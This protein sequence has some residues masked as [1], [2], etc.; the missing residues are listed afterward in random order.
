M[1]ESRGIQANS[2]QNRFSLGKPACEDDD[3]GNLGRPHRRKKGRRRRELRLSLG[4][5]HL[6]SLGLATTKGRCSLPSVR[7]VTTPSIFIIKWRICSNPDLQSVPRTGVYHLSQTISTSLK[8]AVPCLE[9]G[10]ERE[11]PACKKLRARHCLSG[12]GISPQ[13]PAVTAAVKHAIAATPSGVQS[14]YRLLTDM[15]GI[16]T[17]GGRIDTAAA[18]RTHRRDCTKVSIV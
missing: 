8:L 9:D 10:A 11:T 18:H 4:C 7:E 6:A 15:S 12:C 2:S 1:T 17:V 16:S 13:A 3:H 5:A 14:S